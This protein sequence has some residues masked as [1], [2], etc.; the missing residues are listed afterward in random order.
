[1]ETHHFRKN[2]EKLQYHRNI[3]AAFSFIVL[4]SNLT[5]TAI[6]AS[7]RERIVVLPPSVDR[8]FWVEGNAFSPAYIEQFGLFLAQLVLN[9]SPASVELQN[10]ILLR[11]VAPNQYPLL[12]RVLQEEQEEILQNDLTHLFFPTRVNLEH[13]T[14]SLV[15]EGE[16][17]SY[18]SNEPI[19][20]EMQKYILHFT[21]QNGLMQFKELKKIEGKHAS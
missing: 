5:L 21:F 20:Q 13:D 11:H 1:M 12:K 16:R 14:Q 15:L 4:L 19:L 6:V 10:R 8:E 2:V 18:L 9:K 7:K 17:V 3:L